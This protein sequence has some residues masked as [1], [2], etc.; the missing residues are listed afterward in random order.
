[1]RER[2]Q[3][4]I[5]SALETEQGEV[6]SDAP[7]IANICHSFYSKLYSVDPVMAASVAA[8]EDVLAKLTPRITAS[9]QAILNNPL[10]E[11]ELHE[12]CTKLARA[13]SPGPDGIAV[14]MFQEYWDFL[15]FDYSQIVAT[16]LQ[17]GRFP[18]EVTTGQIVLLHKG[19]DRQRLHNWRP[20]TLLNSTYKIVAKAIQLRLQ[21]ILTDVISPEQSTFLPRRYILDNVFL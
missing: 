5:I 4:S 2:P 15:G 7:G 11:E 13:K 19:G 21:A 14:E 3:P 16:A 17:N 20:T 10:T 9:M 6:V 8:C 18:P 12:A 1:M